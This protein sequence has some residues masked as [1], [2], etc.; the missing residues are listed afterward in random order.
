MMRLDLNLIEI[1]CCVYE[2]ANITKA[3]SKLR[4]SQPTVSCHIKHLESYVG[5]KLFD[6]LPRRLAPTYAGKLLYRRGFTIL[7]E[8]EAAMQDL[9]KFLHRIEG[10]LRISGSNILG[11]YVLPH[12]I[13]SFYAQFPAIKVELKIADPKAICDDVLSGEAELGF[14]CFKI[15]SIGLRYRPFASGEI[16]LV[17]PNTKEWRGIKVISLERLAAEP[18]LAREIGSGMRAMVEKKIGRTLEGFNVVG[19]FGSDGVVKEALKAGMGIS[20]VSLFS[21]QQELASGELKTIEIEGVNMQASD[22]SV[23]TNERLTLSPIAETFLASILETK[24]RSEHLLNAS[25]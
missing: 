14:S 3:A 19:V 16:A 1:F 10:S 8:K 18:F 17:V 11:E 5:A 9:E 23:V 25:A 24:G 6:R 20:V 7:K 15:D 22:L 4:I 12:L 13:A 21:V 2:E